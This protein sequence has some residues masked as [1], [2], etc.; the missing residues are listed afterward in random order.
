MGKIRKSLH[1][2][3][4]KGDSRITGIPTNAEN[5][6]RQSRLSGAAVTDIVRPF[7]KQCGERPV[8]FLGCSYTRRKDLIDQMVPAWLAV[9]VYGFGRLITAAGDSGYRCDAVDHGVCFRS[10]ST[11]ITVLPILNITAMYKRTSSYK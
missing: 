2:G 7:Q 5:D 1:T 6:N 4:G 9:I 10:P 8:A 3:G 11:E